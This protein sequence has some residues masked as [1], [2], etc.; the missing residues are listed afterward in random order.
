MEEKNTTEIL[1]S[2][3]SEV[4]S[5]LKEFLEYLQSQKRYSNHTVIS[6][7]T[8]LLYFFDFLQKENFNQNSRQNPE[9]NPGQISKKILEDLTI[10][11]FRSWLVFRKESDFSNSSTARALSCLRSFFAFHNRQKNLKNNQIKNLRTPKLS[12]TIPKAVDEPDI[13]MIAE[14]IN[15]FDQ[16]E[17][18]QKRD[19][20]L[21]TLIYGCGLRISEALGITKEHLVN[22][23]VI[24]ITGKGSKQRMLPVLTIVQNRI[25]EYLA[26]CP[27]N[28]KSDQPIFL[29]ARG[30]KY[31]P[32]LFQK[33][34]SDIRKML[35]LAETVTPHAFRHSFAT[36]LLE[37]GGDLRTIQE[38][39]G[40]SSL[41]TTQRYTKIDKKRLL[42]VYNKSHPR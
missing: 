7:R 13:K 17:W 19:L 12:K 34:I 36:H 39:L 22:P 28:L 20:A 10:H 15:Q 38:L 26:S 41:S 33:L 23:E 8:D 31:N 5:L 6:Y 25:N 42:E 9:Q 32:R 2:I 30:K 4:V 27:Y 3:N 14:A 1:P 40:H 16:E 35:G 24:I 21:L 18:Y 37:A 29:G 11:D